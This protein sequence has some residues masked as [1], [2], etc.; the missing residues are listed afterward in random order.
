MTDY[1]KRIQ[2]RL[3]RKDIKKTRNVLVEEIKW[4]GY[5]SEE[6]SDEL[7]DLIT[8]EL[9]DKFSSNSQC[10]ESNNLPVPQT[11]SFIDGELEQAANPQLPREESSTR[12]I[13]VSS[14]QKH[15]L[16]T[17]QSDVLDVELSD[18]ETIE[19]CSNIPD[20]FDDYETFISSVTDAI[21]IFID[22]KFDKLS[23][24]SVNNS[25]NDLRQ[26]IATRQT[27]LDSKFAAGLNEVRGDLEQIRS[28]LKSRKAAILSRLKINS[29]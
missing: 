15:E 7:A 29:A 17:A 20:V 14:E 1:V 23:K 9:L 26:H 12:E 8:N 10:S 25:I 11:L 19:L 6:L 4:L 13:V 5:N 3:A 18:A 2:S 22:E 21:K 16:V 24:Q 27:R 28:N